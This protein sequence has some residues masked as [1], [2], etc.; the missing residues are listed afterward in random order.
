[1]LPA[2]SILMPCY[3]AAGTLE[4]ALESLYNQTLSDFEII[5]VDDGSTDQTANI[6]QRWAERDR[7]LRVLSSPHQGIIAALNLGLAACRAPYVAR[8]DADDRSMPERLALQVE[9]LNQNPETG[10]VGCLVRGFPA[11]QVREGFRIYLDWLNSLVSGEDI[12]REIFIE[13]PLPHP[14]VT[15]RKELVLGAGGYQERGWAEDYDLWM[16]LYLQG[17]GFAKI[18]T[19][20]LEWREHPQR[21]TRCDSRYSL[22]N[23]LRAK[24]Y[25]L[26]RGPLRDRDAVIIWGAGMMGRRLS[27]HLIREGAPL[28]AFVD[29]DPRKIG[30]TRRGRPVISPDDLP[31]WLQQYQNPV[32]LAA[33]GARGARALIRQ[34]LTA[35]GLCEGKDWWCAA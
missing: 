24:A 17:V 7:R 3:N 2:V 34:Q 16:R 23:F 25:Y 15:F 8:M 18:P 9:Y 32:V 13:S 10:V 5:A 12:R 20:L 19:H 11:D 1:M 28:V 33:V 26:A 35:L 29:I 14:S 4:E 30:H 31:G 21:L 22:E 27:K 6:L